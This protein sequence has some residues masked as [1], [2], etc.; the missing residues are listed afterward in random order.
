MN[1][2]HDKRVHFHTEEW[3]VEESGRSLRH[4]DLP[5]GRSVTRRGRHTSNETAAAAAVIDGNEYPLWDPDLQVSATSF[6][7]VKGQNQV[8]AE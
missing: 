4:D 7:L 2:S 1:V 3:W 5:A 8:S 6:A